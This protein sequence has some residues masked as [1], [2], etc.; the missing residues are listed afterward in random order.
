MVGTS[1]DPSAVPALWAELRPDVTLCDVHM[2]SIDGFDLCRLLHEEQPD[3]PVLLFSARD[4]D[5]V[6]RAAVT[7]G[8]AGLISKT[9]SPAALA[10]ALLATQPLP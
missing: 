2:P 9:A 5:A 4:D 7:A 10:A 1:S 8:A 6:R 3:A